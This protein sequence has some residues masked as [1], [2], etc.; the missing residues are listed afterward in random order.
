MYISEILDNDPSY[1]EI[2]ESC[3]MKDE[4]MV[5]FMEWAFGKVV[6]N[7]PREWYRKWNRFHGKHLMLTKTPHTLTDWAA[8]CSLWGRFKIG[9]L[10]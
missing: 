5:K 1:V 6:S 2:L 4:D 8:L 10:K 7:D 3:G 9:S